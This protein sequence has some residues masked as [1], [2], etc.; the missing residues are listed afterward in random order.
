MPKTSTP[1]PGEHTVSLRKERATWYWFHTNP[2]G[3]GFG[4]NNCGPQSIA[5]GAALRAIPHGT[6]YRLIVNGK[7][8][9]MQ[10]KGVQ[11]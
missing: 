9:G 4:S 3:G 2:E 7:D 8:R 1:M 5:L 11:S 6:Q 10:T